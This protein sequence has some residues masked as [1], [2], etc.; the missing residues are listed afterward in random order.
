M[1]TIGSR[2]LDESLPCI[3]QAVDVVL[4]KRR[5]RGDFA[6]DFR[7]FVMLKL[8]ER[9]G[10]RLRHFRGESTLL[11]YLRVV[12]DRLYCDYLI[13][14]NGKWHRSKKAIELG[15]KAVELERLVYHDG[16]PLDQAIEMMRARHGRDSE[17]DL[18]AF[19]AAIPTRP[20]RYFVGLES[21]SELCAGP[22]FS[23]DSILQE[24]EAESMCHRIRGS[25]ASALA[26]LPEHDRNIL[27]LRFAQGLRISTISRLL[28]LRQSSVYGRVSRIL[29]VLNRKLR[30][31]G[32]DQK[33]IAAILHGS[34][35]L[36]GLEGVLAG[37]SARCAPNDTRRA[38]CSESGRGCVMHPVES[39]DCILPAGASEEIGARLGLA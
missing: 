30:A 34:S 21:V 36:Q 18:G 22:Q 12:V 19:F 3:H 5:R 6:E 27:N 33:S 31:Q 32:I 20:K 13:A 10:A 24:T 35:S 29:R 15:A 2:S 14:G 8:L 1:N 23:P 38:A 7:S 39:R 16:Y 4:R 37:G 28:R 26:D 17:S 9:D 11:T 25:L